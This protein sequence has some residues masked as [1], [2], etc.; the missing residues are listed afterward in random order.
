MAKPKPKKKPEPIKTVKVEVKKPKKEARPHVP[1]VST[2]GDG[3]GQPANEVTHQH[4][5]HGPDRTVSRRVGYFIHQMQLLREDIEGVED[6]TAAKAAPDPK[7]DALIVELKKQI[8]EWQDEKDKIERLYQFAV[9][10]LHDL[11]EN[12]PSWT[13]DEECDHCFNKVALADK[14]AENG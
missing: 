4:I 3:Y 14:A 8:E 11:N 12:C 2:T 6:K 13:L 10:Q 9:K 7:K 1:P 5:G